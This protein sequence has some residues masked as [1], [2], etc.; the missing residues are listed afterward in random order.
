MSKSLGNRWFVV[1]TAFQY[2]VKECI[3]FMLLVKEKDEQ[4]DK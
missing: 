1:N 3:Y 2:V 4:I